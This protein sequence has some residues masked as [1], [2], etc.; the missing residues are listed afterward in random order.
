MDGQAGC[1]PL[2]LAPAGDEPPL[3]APLTARRWPIG[4]LLLWDQLEWEGEVEE[5]ARR[6]LED[7]AGLAAVKGVPASLRAAFAFSAVEAASR[8]LDIAA[9][10][11]EVRRWVGEIADQGYARAEVALRALAGER[12]L[13]ANRQRSDRTGSST[14]RRPRP[15]STW[16]RRWRRRCGRRAPA[17]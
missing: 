14:G 1:R 16:R 8:A 9:Q 17:T 12:P 13:W 11:G 3:L 7:R 2:D 5:T 10:P 4:D 15:R 6:A